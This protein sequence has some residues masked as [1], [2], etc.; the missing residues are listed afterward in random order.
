MNA[1]SQW[2][3]WFHRLWVLAQPI[4]TMFSLGRRSSSEF[5]PG[6]P[7]LPRPGTFA[8]ESV[9]RVRKFAFAWT[10][11]AASFALV[12]SDFGTGDRCGA[13]VRQHIPVQMERSLKVGKRRWRTANIKWGIVLIADLPLRE[14]KLL[15][16]ALTLH[17]HTHYVFK[18]SAQLRTSCWH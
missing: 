6:W 10:K 5:L 1:V 12:V 14:L 2:S 4:L 8:C 16:M 15:A 17:T 11:C 9:S 7:V 3:W 18:W 13:S